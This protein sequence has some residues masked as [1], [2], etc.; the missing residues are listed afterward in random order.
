[1]KK[2][3]LA[4][5][6]IGGVLADEAVEPGMEIPRYDN[7]IDFSLLRVGY[8]RLKPQGVYVGVQ[9]WYTYFPGKHNPQWINIVEG[10]LGYNFMFEGKDRLT[11][12]V[13]GGFYRYFSD[14]KPTAQTRYYYG[15]LYKQGIGYIMAGAAYEHDFNR[16]FSMGLTM[17]LT[18]GTL[19]NNEQVSWGNPIVGYQVEA[20]FTFRFARGRKWDYRS[21]P[22]VVSQMGQYYSSTILGVYGEF[23][24][25][26]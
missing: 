4:I 18:I 16:L 25:R 14:A 17:K 9:E 19:A 3:V 2:V 12:M 7:R 23:G 21:V 11:P 24:Y 13:G 15:N 10:R 26:F 8:E 1:M 20:P 22:F 6:L 5:S